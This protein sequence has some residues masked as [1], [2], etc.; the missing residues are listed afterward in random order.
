[1][2]RPLPHEQKQIFIFWLKTVFK[3]LIHC[4]QTSKMSLKPSCHFQFGN[5]FAALQSILEQ[6]ILLPTYT[7]VTTKV[8][9]SKMYR[10]SI[11]ICVNEIWQQGFFGI[12]SRMRR[13]VYAWSVHEKCAWYLFFPRPS[14]IKVDCKKYFN[15]T[16]KKCS[17]TTSELWRYWYWFNSLLYWHVYSSKG[18]LAKIN[19]SWPFV[20]VVVRNSWDFFINVNTYVMRWTL[21]WDKTGNLFC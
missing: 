7:L 1:M 15:V 4:P 10:T 3:F 19:H 18:L 13:T 17:I 5:L 20:F 16:L 8:S 11:T 21:V 2:R 6:I 9:S 12:F 14:L